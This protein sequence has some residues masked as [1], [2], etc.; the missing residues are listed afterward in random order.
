MVAPIVANAH[1]LDGQVVVFAA[2][3]T[4]AGATT[5]CTATLPTYAPNIDIR[6][7]HPVLSMMSYGNEAGAAVGDKEIWLPENEVLRGTSGDSVGEW[8]ISATNTI[9]IYNTPDKDGF[10][11]ITY[12]AMGGAKA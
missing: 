2:D 5:V 9:E 10:L 4:S 11:I 8:Q 3:Y 6:I 12:I 7:G 1:N